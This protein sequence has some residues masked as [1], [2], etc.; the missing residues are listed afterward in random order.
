MKNS[1]KIILLIVISFLVACKKD[2]NEL[3]LTPETQTG[4]YIFMQ[5][6]LGYLYA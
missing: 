5:N 4:K 6:Q 3:G 2:K 1:I